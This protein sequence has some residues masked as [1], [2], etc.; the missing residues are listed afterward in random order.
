MLQFPLQGCSIQKMAAVPGSHGIAVLALIFYP[1][2]IPVSSSVCISFSP[3]RM[4]SASASLTTAARSA[5]FFPRLPRFTA[6]DSM[7]FPHLI[8]KS[9][10]A[11]KHSEHHE[12]TP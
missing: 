6:L 4:E 11:G 12:L 1:T 5:Q 7:T 8:V 9:S 10:W 2:G 3:R